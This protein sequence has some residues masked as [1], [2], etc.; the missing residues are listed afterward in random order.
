MTTLLSL[1]PDFDLVDA[2]VEY[3][4]RHHAPL[5]TVRLRSV[6]LY[7]STAVERARA[8]VS[9][10]PRFTEHPDIKR[11]KV[12]ASAVIGCCTYEGLMLINQHEYVVQ[13]MELKEDLL[14]NYKFADTQM[15]DDVFS[16]LREYPVALPTAER[17]GQSTAVSI[18]EWLFNKITDTKNSLG[19]SMDAAVLFATAVVLKDLFYM[20]ESHKE[21]LDRS[22]K[23]FFAAVQRRIAIGNRLKPLVDFVAT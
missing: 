23:A 4:P 3:L 13:L 12:S 22:M 7:L 15:E 10:D 1:S 14:L 5:N 21:S 18:P 11:T 20:R 19:C 6:P 2:L 17:R 9:K 8:S 16:I